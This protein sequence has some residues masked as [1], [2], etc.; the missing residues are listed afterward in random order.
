MAARV[1]DA[2]ASNY[3]LSS[4]VAWSTSSR[5]WTYEICD[6]LK[7]AVQ[8]RLES[9]LRKAKLVTKYVYVVYMS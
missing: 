1:A 6:A 5:K 7:V 4:A 8:G 2:G 9:S 3:S